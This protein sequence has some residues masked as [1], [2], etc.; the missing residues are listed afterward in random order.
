MIS[1]MLFLANE[2]DAQTARLQ[3]IHNSPD[4]IADSVDVYLDGNL[5]LDNFAFRTATPFIDAPAG[6]QI[7]ID[8]AP[9][10]STS[11][12]Q[13]I[14]NFPLTLTANETYVA[15]ANGITG[16]SSTTYTPAPAFDLSIYAQGQ[17]TATTSGN[18][19]VLVHHGSTDAPIVD[20][21]E[22]SVPAGTIV[23]DAAYGDFSGYLDLSNLDYVLEVQDQTGSTTVASYQA[24]L[25]TLGL[26]DSALVVVASGFLDPS[27]NG[28][29]PAFGLYVALPSGG[30]LIALPESTTTNISEDDKINLTI[31][32]NP[33]TEIIFI[34]G[35]SNIKGNITNLSG[36]VVLDFNS[37]SVDLSSLPSGLFFVNV[38]INESVS[39]HKIIK[40]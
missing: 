33:A 32:P 36:K 15:V 4:D 17:E 2:S 13:S 37:N 19:S 28:N 5:L 21:A 16:L 27:V 10:T 9:K 12:A 11:V 26:A 35:A 40:Q 18:T 14:A 38:N 29:G 3:V 39:V 34:T 30:E 24:P 31:Y 1:G 8:I 7:Q 23:N 6:V 22:V 20:V 25:S